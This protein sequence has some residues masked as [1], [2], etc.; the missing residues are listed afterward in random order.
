MAGIE[1]APPPGGERWGRRVCARAV[2]QGILLRP[3]GDVVVVMPPLTTTAAEIEHVVEVL[4]G[5]IDA[6]WSE[7]H[8]APS[9]EG[10]A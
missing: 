7:D 9:A 8:R 10:S 6:V 1:L 3:L 2:D 5:S 4:A